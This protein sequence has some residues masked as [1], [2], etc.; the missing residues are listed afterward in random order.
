MGRPCSTPVHFWSRYRRIGKCLIWQGALVYGYGTLTYGNENWRAHR[1][2]WT[3]KKGPIP[4]GKE[5][6][7]KCD[8]KRCGE[9]QHLFLGTQAENIEDKCHKG[10]Q[11]IGERIGTAKLRSRQIH[12]IRY[13]F[14]RGSSKTQLAQEFRVTRQQINHIVKR[15]QW[16]HI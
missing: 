8:I 6:L 12:R 9:L 1:L 7:H 14:E 4:K 2:A 13:K 16:K 11:A 5:V 10:R 3:L 15:K